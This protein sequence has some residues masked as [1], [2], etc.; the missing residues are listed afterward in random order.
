MPETIWEGSMQ[1][2]MFLV[3][4]GALLVLSGVVLV[5]VQA[6]KS[7]RLSD[8]R[9][10]RSVVADASLEPKGR[11]G[12]FDLKA[13]WPGLGLITLGVILLITVAAV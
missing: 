11:S 10:P 8:A 1:S 5:A 3:G 4:V 9:R 13:H 2:S 6:L 7:G 12:I